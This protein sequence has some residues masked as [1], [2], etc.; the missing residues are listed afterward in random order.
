MTRVWIFLAL[1]LTA[2]C[3]EYTP[4]SGDTATKPPTDKVKEVVSAVTGIS[5]IQDHHEDLKAEI[6]KA[7]AAKGTGKPSPEWMVRNQLKGVDQL[8]Q[9]CERAR[10]E[11]AR[12]RTKFSADKMLA[13]QGKLHKKRG[14]LF[15]ERKEIEGTIQAARLGTGKIPR[16]F[17]EAELRDRVGD[18]ALKIKEIEKEIDSMQQRL[19]GAKDA[20]E[21]DNY[22]FGD[23]LFTRE[24]DELKKTR[25][26]ATRLLE[27]P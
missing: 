25:K 8:I 2:A 17:T 23:S 16:G 18:I 6:A 11:E 1:S 13:D 15:E 24:L 10:L 26:R 21:N 5:K 9:A 19:L 20:V 7:E 14:E 12:Q 27:K 3:D 4:T 22:D